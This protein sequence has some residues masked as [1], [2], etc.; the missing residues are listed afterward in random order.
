MKRAVVAAVVLLAI[1][2]GWASLAQVPGQSSPSEAMPGEVARP[3]PVAKP[4]AAAPEAAPVVRPVEA[5][6]APSDVTPP[7]PVP[8]VPIPPIPEVDKEPF[9]PGPPPV[10]QPKPD[11]LEEGKRLFNRE[12]RMEMDAI[13]RPVFVFDS[14]EKPMR[15]LENSWREYL[16]TRTDRGK[17]KAHWRISGVVMVYEGTNFLLLTK[18]VHLLAE[19]ENL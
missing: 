7:P 1:G 14:G 9:K 18:A 10:R 12:G 4:Q 15:I 11:I 17:K 2:A 5:A 8:D 16:E 13:G 19:E 3:F 6:P